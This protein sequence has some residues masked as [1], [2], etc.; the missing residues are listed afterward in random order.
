MYG[1]WVRIIYLQKFVARVCGAN[2]DMAGPGR[3]PDAHCFI[4]PFFVY[5]GS[6][7]NS[8]YPD[9]K[10]IGARSS[11]RE[12]TEVTDNRVRHSTLGKD[13]FNLYEILRQTHTQKRKYPTPDINT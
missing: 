5:L 9:A 13:A 4:E 12:L 11:S 10:D 1:T 6:L 8:L 7:S 2:L 3:H